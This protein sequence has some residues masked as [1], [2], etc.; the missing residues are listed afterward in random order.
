MKHFTIMIK[1][2]SAL[3]NL[4]CKYCFYANISSLREVRSYG[5]MSLDTMKRMLD[6]I[7]IDLDDGD[8]LSFAFQGGEPT[9]AGLS[10]FQEFVAYN[11][12]QTKNITVNYSIQTNGTLLTDDWGYFLKKHQFLVGI[13]IDGTLANHNLNRL[14]MNGQG[15]YRH[16]L[17]GKEILE[18]YEIEHNVLCVLTEKLAQQPDEVYQF[19][20][21]MQ[22]DYVQLIPCLNDLDKV[23]K[24]EYALTPESFASFYK[25]I[26]DLWQQDFIDGDY[27]SF[28]L[29]D[30][31][32]HQISGHGI[33]SCGL[34]GQCGIQYIVEA[35]GSVYPCDFYVLDEYRLGNL[36]DGTGTIMDMLKNKIRHQFLCEKNKPYD[37]CEDC[38]FVRLCGGGCK[39]MKDA[40]YLNETAT[41]CGYQDFL[42][43][44]LP[45]MARLAQA[46]YG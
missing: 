20:K 39:R 34:N 4:R 29:I 22:I 2:A 15:T 6:N 42:E 14:D 1:P 21:E 46:L 8:T 44:K 17:R 19:V 25:R 33:M 26:Y 40:M 5:R 7:Y 10:F 30:A 37:Y 11:Q 3:C 27:T 35:D 12:Q 41:Y 9:L 31:I 32:I 13:S 23:E 36:A 16:V 18:K 28:N 45:Q 24:N 43:E 38:P